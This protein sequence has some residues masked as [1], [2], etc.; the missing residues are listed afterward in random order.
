[1]HTGVA[2]SHDQFIQQNKIFS[3]TTLSDFAQT[4]QLE[5]KVLAYVS[6]LGLRKVLQKCL[7]NINN[8]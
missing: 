1:M 7:E 4:W 8:C 6:Y 2:T 3:M 5:S